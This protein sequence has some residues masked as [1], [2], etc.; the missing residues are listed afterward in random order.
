LHDAP[1]GLARHKFERLRELRAVVETLRCEREARDPLLAW[2]VDQETAENH[3][4]D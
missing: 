4:R 1:E 3:R 2:V